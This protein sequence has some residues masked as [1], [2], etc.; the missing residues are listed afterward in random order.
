MVAGGR[1]PLDGEYLEGCSELKDFLG[2]MSMRSPFRLGLIRAPFRKDSGECCVQGQD[3][4]PLTLLLPFAPSGGTL[5]HP[6]APKPPLCHAEQL[7]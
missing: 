5:S 1:A 3:F 6:E 7:P 4:C 2:A